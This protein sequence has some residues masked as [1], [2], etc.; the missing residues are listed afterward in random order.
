MYATPRESSRVNQTSHAP[1]RR[2]NNEVIK[3]ML[4]GTTIPH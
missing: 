3:T 1:T 2:A 4:S